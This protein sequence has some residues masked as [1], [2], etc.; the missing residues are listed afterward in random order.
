MKLCFTRTIIRTPEIAASA[1]LAAPVGKRDAHQRRSLPGECLAN[2][3]RNRVS[4]TAARSQSAALTLG[5]RGTMILP[6]VLSVILFAI[7]A[8]FLLLP[9]RHSGKIHIL[10]A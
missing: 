8:G 10:P 4:P 1:S 5:S 3:H 6:T 9:A 7:V 2:D